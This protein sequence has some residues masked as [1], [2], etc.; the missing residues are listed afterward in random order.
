MNHYSEGIQTKKVNYD[1]KDNHS[2]K[3]N[4]IP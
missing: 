4:H 1:W 3:M 2:L